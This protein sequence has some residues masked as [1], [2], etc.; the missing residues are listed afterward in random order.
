M[1]LQLKE[2][3]ENPIKDEEKIKKIKKM[4]KLK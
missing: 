1:T 4:K 3:F 2:I